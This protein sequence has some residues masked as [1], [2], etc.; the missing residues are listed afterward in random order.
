MHIL[1]EI[2]QLASV[3]RRH[4]G[5]D[6]RRQ[7]IQRLKISVRWIRGQYPAI[8]CLH[9][10]GKKQVVAFWKAHRD[11][12]GGTSR[13]YW[14]AFCQLW[15]WLDRPGMPPEPRLSGRGCG[16]PRHDRGVQESHG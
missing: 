13:G 2:D 15:T 14:L 5:K 11:M 9:Q 3:Y 8:R 6:N 16:G 1:D 4:G 7:Q 10:I 12:A